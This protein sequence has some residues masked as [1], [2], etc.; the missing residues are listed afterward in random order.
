MAAA[1]SKPCEFRVVPLKVNETSIAIHYLFY[2]QH[3]VREQLESKPIDRTLFVVNVPPY[4]GHQSLKSIF[5]KC[6]SIEK[7]II[8]QKPTLG[9]EEKPDSKYF[10][11]DKPIEGFCV[12][13]IVF[14]KSSALKKCHILE[15]SSP[16]CLTSD[17]RLKVGIEKWCT[18]YNNN[19][20]NIE[21][22]QK[23]IDVYMQQYDEKVEKEKQEAIEMEG[24]ADEEGWI[25][26]SKHSKKPVIRRTEVNEK[27]ITAKERKKRSKKNL[28]NFYTFQIRESKMKHIEEL[29]KKFEED[30]RRIELMKSKRKFKPF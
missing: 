19:I 8:H 4:C 22:L 21:E 27:K 13:Y 11:K 26:V 1:T 16:C 6:G 10:P 29:R 18:E 23:E 14:K 9:N 2:K 15:E 7:I 24:V 28:L 25:T 17:R 20:P 3:R 12:A 30:K 5:S